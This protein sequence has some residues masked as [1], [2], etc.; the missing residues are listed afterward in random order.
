MSSLANP[1]HMLNRKVTALLPWQCVLME[2]FAED[3]NPSARIIERF[4]PPGG[5]QQTVHR[6]V[7]IATV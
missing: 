2:G 1:H 7:L 5:I 3:F 6:G 4:L